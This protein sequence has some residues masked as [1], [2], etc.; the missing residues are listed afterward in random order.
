M[1]LP[2]THHEQQLPLRLGA[3]R[4]GL[5]SRSRH[6]EA[7]HRHGRSCTSRWNSRWADRNAASGRCVPG[8]RSRAVP[9]FDDRL[10]PLIAPSLEPVP[11]CA[12]SIG[13]GEHGHYGSDLQFGQLVR[14]GGIIGREIDRETGLGRRNNGVVAEDGLVGEGDYVLAGVGSDELLQ[15][16]TINLRTMSWQVACLGITPETSGMET[17]DFRAELQ[18]GATSE[19]AGHA[20]PV[21]GE[22]AGFG[23]AAVFVECAA[24]PA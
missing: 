20:I 15:E 24:R 1:A 2:G 23:V 19:T 8:Q 3:K 9:P 18:P 6:P 17:R 16:R 13:S 10:G 5:G 12:A 21:H 7:G 22:G 4:H 14:M 11:N